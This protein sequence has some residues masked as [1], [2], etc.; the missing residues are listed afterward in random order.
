MDTITA[1]K[2][3]V[4]YDTFYG[5]IKATVTIG[6][7]TYTAL[8]ATKEAAYNRLSEKIERLKNS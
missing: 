1:Q 7:T 5:S 4:N 2:Y 8:G 3:K 6:W